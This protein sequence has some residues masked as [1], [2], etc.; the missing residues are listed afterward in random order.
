MD[1]G[2]GGQTDGR[3]EGCLGGWMEGWIDG[4]FDVPMVGRMD[5]YI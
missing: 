5:G 3:L 1:A 2:M 4:C